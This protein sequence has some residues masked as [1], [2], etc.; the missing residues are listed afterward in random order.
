MRKLNLPKV[1]DVPT[2][3]LGILFDHRCDICDLC[4]WATNVKIKPRYG[5]K[6]VKILMIGEA[7]GPQEDQKGTAFIGPSGITIDTCVHDAGVPS[8]HVGFT[9]V[10]RC[11]PWKDPSLRMGIRQPS[12]E[13][14]YNCGAAY[15]FREIGHVKPDIIVTLG[16][17]SAKFLLGDRLVGSL[18]RIRGRIFDVSIYGNTYPVIPTYH[19]ASVLRGQVQNRQ[20]IIRDIRRAWKI[21]TGEKYYYSPTTHIINDTYKAIELLHDICDMKE[22]GS[23]EYCSYDIESTGFDPWSNEILGFSVS[24]DPKVGYFIPLYHT[25]SDVDVDKLMPAFKRFSSTVPIVAHNAKFDF[26]WTFIRLGVELDIELDTFLISSLTYGETRRHK[27]EELAQDLLDFNDYDTSL[28]KYVET[29]PASKR[30]FGN[31]P[32]ELL[33]TY[34]AMDAIATRCLAPIMKENIKT[35]GLEYPWNLLLESIYVF[36]EIELNGWAVDRDKL[37]ELKKLYPERVMVYFKKLLRSEGAKNFLRQ[38]EE[39]KKLAP[40]LHRL[41]DIDSFDEGEM[42]VIYKKCNPMSHKQ[43]RTIMYDYYKAPVLEKEK[44]KKTEEPST[45]EKSILNAIKYFKSE[46]GNEDA[47]EFHQNLWVCR[48]I[49]KSISAYIKG[50][51]KHLRE[52]QE[53]DIINFVYNLSGTVTGRFSTRTYAIHTTPRKSDIKRLFRSF[54]HD[55]GGLIIDGDYSQW[56]MRIFA[57]E[58]EETGMIEAFKRGYDIYRYI[59]SIIYEKGMEDITDEERQISKKIAL[60]LIYGLGIESIAEQCFIPV[61]QAED[62]LSRFFTKFPGAK[63]YTTRIHRRMKT[64]GFVRT[65]LGRIRHF[66]MAMGDRDVPKWKMHKMEREAQNFPIQSVASDLTLTGLLSFFVRLRKGGFKSRIL[67]F[68]HDGIPADVYPGELF[69]MMH[70]FK[71]AMNDDLTEMYEWLTIPVKSDFKLGKTWGSTLEVKDWRDGY[72]KLKGKKEY[73]EDLIDTLGKNYTFE[74]EI[75]DEFEVKEQ[76]FILGKAYQGYSEDNGYVVAEIR[77]AKTIQEVPWIDVR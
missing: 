55:R 35:H 63:N 77:D 15:L 11:I 12:Q 47:H 66:P 56:E 36:S 73:F 43:M 71:K 6:R 65:R 44:S 29:L 58:S 52:G 1:D 37:E 54:W 25:E 28:H 76:E 41:D 10:V 68:V 22:S 31:V 72:L 7:P 21:A 33:G 45:N 5:G 53:E 38:Q 16:V 24:H 34:G 51:P 74:W 57:L 69:P 9:N 60:G 39:D 13:E 18:G 49:N 67:G 50:I 61:Y 8:S 14:V 19:P 26:L 23:I 20:D 48:K 30:H 42:K 62:V 3:E 64:D 40:L 75:L 59:G 32:L 2:R 17:P 46:D 27:L 70:Q 4:H